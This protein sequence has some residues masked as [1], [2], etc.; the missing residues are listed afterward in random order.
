VF[1]GAYALG[2]LRLRVWKKS[3]LCN[4]LSLGYRFCFCSVRQSLN[5]G[6]WCSSREGVYFLTIACHEAFVCRRLDCRVNLGLI[7]QVSGPWLLRLES[8]I[9]R[10]QS[11][12]SSCLTCRSRACHISIPSTYAV[13]RP[14]TCVRYLMLC[15]LTSCSF[16]C[17]VPRY[18][19]PPRGGK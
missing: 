2:W 18:R 19:L 5:S 9:R 13:T 4:H 11:S 7:F 15:K 16:C 17:V 10:T 8:S 6:V 14:Q 3:V 12:S 1:T